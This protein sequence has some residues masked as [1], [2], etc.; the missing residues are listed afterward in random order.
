MMMQCFEYRAGGRGKRRGFAHDACVPTREDGSRQWD[1]KVVV[2]R[3]DLDGERCV[4]CFG[5][6][7]ASQDREAAR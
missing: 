2:P 1:T 4:L 7:V 5:L 6:M 3:A